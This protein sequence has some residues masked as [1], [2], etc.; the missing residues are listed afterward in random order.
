[1]FKFILF[2]NYTVANKTAVK[3]ES[4][5]SEKVLLRSAFEKYFVQRWN[6]DLGAE[7]A[8]QCLNWPNVLVKQQTNAR[9]LLHKMKNKRLLLTNKVSRKL[10]F[11]FAVQKCG[12]SFG[13]CNFVFRIWFNGKKSEWWVVSVAI[14]CM[15][16]QQEWIFDSKWGGGISD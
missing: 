16:F 9:P 1:M 3:I 5:N 6:G 2:V 13:L 4:D 15:W 7:S 11:F 8:V 14:V 12:H 10:Q